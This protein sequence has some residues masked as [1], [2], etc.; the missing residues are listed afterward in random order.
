[1]LKKKKAFSSFSVDDIARAKAFY[2]ETLGLDVEDGEMGTL[3]I[4]LSGGSD[5]LIYPKGEAHSAASFT[6][7]NFLVDDID[8]AVDR[9]TAEGVRFEQ[10]SGEIQTDEKG[11][12]R[13]TGPS[14]G[15]TVAWFKDPAGNILS[16]LESE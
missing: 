8:E 12:A 7:L 5:L 11:I 1:M 9:L 14:R 10:Y 4:H 2:G 13:S 6:V 15:P 3:E 16:V